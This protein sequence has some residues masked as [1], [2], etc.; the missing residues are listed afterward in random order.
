LRAQP[1]NEVAALFGLGNGVQVPQQAQTSPVQVA[2]PD[3]Q[4]LVSSNYKTA[5][6]NAASGNATTATAVATAAA[7]AI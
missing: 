6:A 2:A 4:G 7:I 1:I 3:Y 5:A